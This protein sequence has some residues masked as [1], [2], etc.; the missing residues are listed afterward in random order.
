[1][2][3]MIWAMKCK[4]PQKLGYP[5]AMDVKFIASNLELIIE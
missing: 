5:K 4:F 1:M 2:E 3:T